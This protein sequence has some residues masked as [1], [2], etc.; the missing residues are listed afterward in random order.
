M[1]IVRRMTIEHTQS[2]LTVFGSGELSIN[3]VNEVL[4]CLPQNYAGQTDGD[5][6]HEPIDEADFTFADPKQSSSRLKFYKVLIPK[7]QHVHDRSITSEK[8]Y[9]S[10]ITEKVC[11][12]CAEIGRV[13]Q[14]AEEILMHGSGLAEWKDKS[15]F[16][17]QEIAWVLEEGNAN[18]TIKRTAAALDF[19]HRHKELMIPRFKLRNTWHYDL[20]I[21]VGSKEDRRE[22]QMFFKR[23]SPDTL[24]EIVRLRKCLD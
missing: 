9:R 10:I 1:G 8:A 23:C 12:E 20:G 17:V 15:M 24:A 18:F 22:R 2:G 5:L 13:A 14:V 16:T 7:Y 4:D 11:D 3:E 6:E 19:L 21:L